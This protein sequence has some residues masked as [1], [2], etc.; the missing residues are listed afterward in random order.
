MSIVIITIIIIAQIIN[1]N[2]MT[3][4]KD[5]LAAKISIEKCQNSENTTAKKRQCGLDFL[6][7]IINRQKYIRAEQPCDSAFPPEKV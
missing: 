7:E 4:G 5:A 3:A 6:M 1:K 2:K